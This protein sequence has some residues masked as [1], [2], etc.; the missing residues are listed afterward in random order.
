MLLEFGFLRDKVDNDQFLEFLVDVFSLVCLKSCFFKLWR[1]E[2][3]RMSLDLSVGT[4]AKLLDD[5][6]EKMHRGKFHIS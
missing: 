4:C 1:V 6:E 3:K 2:R 5:W